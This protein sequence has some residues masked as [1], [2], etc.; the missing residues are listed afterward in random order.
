[1]DDLV[2]SLAPYGNASVH[3]FSAHDDTCLIG[4]GCQGLGLVSRQNH[5][6]NRAPFSAIPYPTFTG[7]AS[8]GVAS[9][10][11]QSPNAGDTFPEANT[12][13]P[14]SRMPSPGCDDPEPAAPEMVSLASRHGALGPPPQNDELLEDYAPSEAES[15][16][17][18]DSQCSGSKGPCSAGTCDFVTACRDENC[19]RPVVEPDVAHS[20]FILQTMTS[21]KEASANLVSFQDRKF[22][23]FPPYSDNIHR[24]ERCYSDH[25]LKRPTRPLQLST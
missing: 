1:M 22:N 21:A 10:S 17:S 8:H 15:N 3:E 25:R 23:T 7:F 20:A 24:A 12:G 2:L 5:H 19:T 16:A 11:P 4:A 6:D 9:P 18:C 13:K 14:Q